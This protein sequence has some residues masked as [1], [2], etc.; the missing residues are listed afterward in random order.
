[1]LHNESALHGCPAEKKPG[2][3]PSAGFLVILRSG[4]SGVNIRKSRQ[5]RTF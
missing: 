4:F 2:K 1:M 3:L 5:L